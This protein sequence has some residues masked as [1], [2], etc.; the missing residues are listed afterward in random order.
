MNK[1]TQSV[2]LRLSEIDPNRGQIPGLPKNPRI[3]RNSKFDLLK[4]SLS[5]NPEMT[6]YRELLVF[7]H[8]GRYVI[9]GGNM[10]YAAMKELGI[11]QTPCKIIDEC[12]TVEQLQQY[13]LKDNS[14]FGEWDFELIANEWDTELAIGCGLDVPDINAAADEKDVVEDDFDEE[15]E[16]VVDFVKPGDMYR[17]GEHYILCG[18]STKEEDV[19]RL[20]GGK[21]V[22]LVFTD[23]PYGVSYTGANNQK[24][25]SWDM[26]AN[27]G[28]R[29]DQLYQ[30]LLAS[31]KN[32]A[33]S[34]KKGGAF[35]VWF[36]AAN[37]IQFE[38]ALRHAGLKVKQEII[39]DRGM[40]LGRS[41]YH[42]AYEPCLYGCHEDKN[43]TW[44]GDRAEKTFW[45]F[46]RT[47]IRKMTREEMEK[48]LLALNDG[49]CIW[50][51]KRDSVIDYVHPTQKP[52][53]LAAKAMKN[54]STVRHT[55][56]NLFSGSGSTLIAAEQLGRKFRG[57]EFD[58]HYASV[59]VTRF[60]KFQGTDA[61]IAR[62]NNDG[63]ETPLSEIE[64]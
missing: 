56:L 59:I 57:M 26:I 14:Q 49:R 10:R 23:P 11:E 8:D 50:Q 45:A 16:K 61:N 54:S 40:V 15:T 58:P 55:V 20:T 43:S 2:M 32:V 12:A 48:M 17:L 6:S 22:D 13:T 42:W 21:H 24:G 29:G 25:K 18:D 41:D 27:D 35:Y 5:D 31:F 64:R 46:N 34:L 33:R 52:V 4:K 38:Q 3:I 19:T 28:L 44:Y 37:H 53:A 9:I 39:W 1:T 51:I 63:T 60:E 7:K 62:V 47:D 36:A 30:F